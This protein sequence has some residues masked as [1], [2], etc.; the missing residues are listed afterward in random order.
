MKDLAGKPL[1]LIDG[2]YLTIGLDWQWW[3]APTRPLLKIN[4]LE[5]M[6]TFK[7]VK[8]LDTFEEEDSDPNNKYF[9]K[10]RMRVDKEKQIIIVC[11]L[12]MTALW[13]LIVRYKI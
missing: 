12:V 7:Q 9:A 10:E 1:D 11:Y 5:Q 13:L 3:L 2:L 6:Y 4:F 8:S